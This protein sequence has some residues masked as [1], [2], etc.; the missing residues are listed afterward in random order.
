[1]ILY[2]WLE[3]IWQKLLQLFMQQRVPHALLFYGPKGLGKTLIAQAF[4]QL[5]LCQTPSATGA[6]QQC[7]SC[8]LFQQ[9]HHPDSLRK[10]EQEPIGIDDI[11]AVSHFLDQTSHQKGKKV[12]T[13]FD[14]DKLQTGSG[15]ALLKTLEE[16][17]GDTV[18]I[19]VATHNN[20]LPTLKSRIQYCLGYRKSFQRAPWKN[21]NRGYFLQVALLY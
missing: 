7:R 15:N 4:E 11:R 14:V 20:I 19:L 13:L 8:F 12:V 10:G 2:P 1:M 6:C 16:P 9:Q 17:Q 18:L 5:L 21:A 3:P